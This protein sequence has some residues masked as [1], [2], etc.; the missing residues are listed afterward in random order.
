MNIVHRWYCKSDMWA[1]QLVRGMTFATSDLDLGDNL[2]EIGPGPGVGTGWVKERVRK[3]TPTEIDH[4]LPRSLRQRVGGRTRTGHRGGGG[5]TKW[6]SGRYEVAR[7]TRSWPKQ[8]ACCLRSWQ[9]APATLGIVS[10]ND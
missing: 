9:Q 6:G 8:R 5:R 2:L 4:K 1:K 7:Q 10:R 3:R